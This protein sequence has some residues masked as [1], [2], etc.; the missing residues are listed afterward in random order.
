MPISNAISSSRFALEVD[1]VAVGGLKSFSGLGAEGTIAQNNT[2]PNAQPKK[3]MAGFAWTPGRAS[4]G[5][6]MGKALY[7]W[8]KGAL[9][10]SNFPHNG[11]F[12]S[13]D[14]NGKVR[15]LRSFSNAVLTEFTVPS[16]DASSREAGYFDMA[17]EAERVTWGTGNGEALP[18]AAVHPKNWVSSN[19]KVTIGDLP[20]A[21][22]A[23]V[24][25]FTWRCTANNGGVGTAHGGNAQQAARATVPDLS[26][27]ISAADYPAWQ[28]AAKKWFAEG[29]SLEAN[30]MKGRISLLG[31]TMKDS[32]E[33]GAIEL[34]NVG[35]R[36][37]DHELAV[38]GSEQIARFA[39][40]LYVERMALSIKDYEG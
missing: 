39:V 31:P 16:L 28:A 40:V 2:G 37:F 6:A 5:I 38:A 36:R 33:L 10:A 34:F 14:G 17:F 19:F 32:D 12:K 29:A 25:A 20:C 18:P 11:A 9:A 1:G 13:A 30:E 24:D 26:L 15:A 7:S 35:F 22:V 3:H 4:T 23:K 21:R 27:S 8:V